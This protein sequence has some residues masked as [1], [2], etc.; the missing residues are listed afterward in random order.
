MWS[1]LV[2]LF[3]GRRASAQSNS[4]AV[5]RVP[6]QVTAHD[7]SLAAIPVYPPLDAGI[8]VVAAGKIVA[9]NSDV[10]SRLRRH[11]SMDE[12]AFAADYLHPIHRLCG[13]VGLLPASRERHHTGQGGLARLCLEFGLFATQASGG[14]MFSAQAGI[15][16]RRAVEA[17]WQHAAF[18][19]G[20]AM[21]LH[22]PLTEMTVVSQDGRKWSPLLGPLEVWA[23]RAGIERV[24]VRWTDPT[25][26]PQGGQATAVWALNHIAGQDILARLNSV[27]ESIVQTMVAAV[28]DTIG[29]AKDHQLARVL[30]DV[31]ARIIARDEGLQPDLYGRL[32][33]GAHIEPWFLDA[34]RSLVRAGK[35]TVNE[36][37]GRLHYLPEGL[38]VTW[39]LGYADVRRELTGRGIS[40]VPENEATGA[41]L[42]VNAGVFLRNPGDGT[43]YWMIKGAPDG[44]SICAVR[45]SNPNSLL[46]VLETQPEPRSFEPVVAKVEVPLADQIKNAQVVVEDAAAA[47]PTT[48]QVECV[49]AEPVPDPQEA[50]GQPVRENEPPAQSTP[51]VDGRKAPAGGRRAPSHEA[52]LPTDAHAVS[53]APDAD[54][55]KITQPNK[56]KAVKVERDK[57]DATPDLGDLDPSIRGSLPTIVA[58]TLVIWRDTWNS[59]RNRKNFALRPEGLAIRDELVRTC[60]IDRNRLIEPLKAAGALVMIRKGDKDRPFIQSEFSDGPDYGY[61]LTAAFARRAGFVLP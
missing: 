30:R 52:P 49:V 24:Y 2:S 46:A 42:L 41:S 47:E 26:R 39:P 54:G 23:G 11:L 44:G 27:D 9:A 15:E 29:R 17:A 16:K 37:S 60:G 38:F 57:E 40:G 36:K 22:R 55:T 20:L 4:T 5:V 6:V 32:T 48:P 31:R 14:V 8:A 56:P 43:H 35:W 3:K 50:P 19:C 51:S 12:V 10:V 33:Q 21:E 34:M 61:V 13:L 59:G 58:R 28:S 53:K 25:D 7:R 45:V 18:L 1:Q